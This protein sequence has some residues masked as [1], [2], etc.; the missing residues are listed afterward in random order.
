[1]K[2]W[3]EKGLGGKTITRMLPENER[4]VE[5]LRKLAEDGKV[6]DRESLG[7]DPEVWEE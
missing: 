1:M 3:T 2:T 6:D 5:K 4:D 7:D